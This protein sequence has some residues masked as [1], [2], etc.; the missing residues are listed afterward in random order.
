MGCEDKYNRDEEQKEKD[1][2][3]LDKLGKWVS[4][5]LFSFEE[6]VILLVIS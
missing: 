5:E 3:E 4:L 1:H 6:N 2:G